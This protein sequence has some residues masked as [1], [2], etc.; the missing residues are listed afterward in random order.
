MTSFWDDPAS[1]P[2]SAWPAQPGASITGTITRMAV[3]QSRYGRLALCVELDGDG[4][5][6][7]CNTGLWRE[8]GAARVEL[9]DRIVVTRKDD[10]W[11]V[12]RATQNAETR[13]GVVEPTPGTAGPSW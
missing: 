7:W 6:R 9:G 8:L 10:G 13:S 4:K 12:L 2:A 3:R 11:D 1:W 5:E